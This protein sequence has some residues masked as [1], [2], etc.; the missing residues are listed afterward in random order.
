MSTTPDMTTG[1]EPGDGEFSR[2]VWW[3][4][5]GLF[6]AIAA[7]LL[8]YVFVD[9]IHRSLRPL[10]S[11]Y[12]DP[13]VSAKLA[14]IFLPALLWLIVVRHRRMAW[15]W[16]AWWGLLGLGVL[17]DAIIAARI[18]GGGA[19]DWLTLTADAPWGSAFIAATCFVALGASQMWVAY[20]AKCAEEPSVCPETRRRRMWSLA[21]DFALLVPL[22]TMAL[23]MAWGI[24]EPFNAPQWR[25]CG[26][27]PNFQYLASCQRMEWGENSRAKMLEDLVAHHLHQGT[28]YSDLLALLGRPDGYA[29][30]IVYEILPKPTISQT[31]V[32]T[33]KW[34]SPTPALH[35]SFYSMPRDIAFLQDF[36]IR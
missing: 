15:L 26:D 32:A 18:Q 11:P 16:G 3:H 36:H 23:V 34:G 2:R 21:A 22:L 4:V 1:P 30:G 35:L 28:R 29:K 20:T 8:S 5:A 10:P 13:F 14:A 25:G 24:P 6:G 33:V 9:V 7:M 12:V 19:F 17:V 27:L 31:M